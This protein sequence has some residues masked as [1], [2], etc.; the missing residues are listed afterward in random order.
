MAT[1][2]GLIRSSQSYTWTAPIFKYVTGNEAARSIIID[3]SVVTADGDG[4]KILR[5]GTLVLQMTS[6]ANS[7]RFGPYASGATDGRQTLARGKAFILGED[8]E[9]TYIDEWT[10]AVAGENPTPAS[11][12]FGYC[13]FATSALTLNS[14]SVANVQAAMPTCEF[15]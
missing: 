13:V 6:G 5:A 15:F 3:P 7:G 11:G 4:R 10:G 14:A 2:Y 9:C 12:L 8:V 1:N